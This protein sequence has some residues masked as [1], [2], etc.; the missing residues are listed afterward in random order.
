L[1][2]IG[3]WLL[4]FDADG[5]QLLPIDKLASFGNTTLTVRREV[6]HG[7]VDEKA[8]KR[9]GENCTIL[10]R[11]SEGEENFWKVL[12][13]DG[14][15]VWFK[16]D[17]VQDV[18][19]AEIKKVKP[20]NLEH[21]D[22]QAVDN[23]LKKLI[24]P[25][26][27]GENGA[28]PGVSREFFLLALQSL[29]S[30]TT[31]WDYNEEV[32][33]YWFSDST[34]REAIAAFR[35]VGQILGNAICMGMLLP[36]SFPDTLYSMLLRGLGSSVPGKWSLEDLRKVSPS[37]ARSFEQLIEYDKDDIA[38]LFTLEW[39]RGDELATLP[40][41][42]R[43][44]YVQSYVEWFFDE[45]FKA[46]A[47][48]LCQGFGAVVG[49]SQLLRKLVSIEQFGQ[50]LIGVEEPVDMVAIRRRA[51]EVGWSS[52]EEKQYLDSFWRIVT[53]FN[54]EQRRKFAVFVSSSARAPLKGW[55]DFGIQVQKN[56][57]GDERMP[58]AYTCFSLLLLPMYTSEE[59]LHTRLLHAIDETQGFG[60]Y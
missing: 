6:R 59:L 31:F 52:D 29:L 32:R 58:T 15:M 60:L 45:R 18:T 48:A 19:S 44:S 36:N 34:S 12:L 23:T 49:H 46:Q 7:R 30:C 28:G 16:K 21:A 33:T 11:D 17:E 55:A 9:C 54:E 13:Q 51:Q 2:H 14:E 3:S 20:L 4:F 26:F 35:A 56:G 10:I 27:A 37:F 42:A 43:G 40:K 5:K 57:T 1:K 8:S 38:S 50:I 39:P 47:D 24:D 53:S 41:D 22:E 25:R